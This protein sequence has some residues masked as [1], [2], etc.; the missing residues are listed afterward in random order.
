MKTTPICNYCNVREGKYYFKT[1]NTWCC[2]KH[3]NACPSYKEKNRKRNL[4]NSPHKQLR[5]DLK[6]GK[7]KCY[8]CGF[9]AR[10][11]VTGNR[12]CCK[13][14]ARRC[15]GHYDYISGFK[16]EYY[17]D[18]RS[19]FYGKKRPNHSK[20]LMKVNEFGKLGQSGWWHKKVHELYHTGVCEICGKTDQEQIDDFGRGLTMHCHTEDYTN[21]DKDNWTEVCVVCHRKI[22]SKDGAAYLLKMAS[23]GGR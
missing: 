4:V 22:H 12:P 7:L 10:Y 17:K 21:M 23:N 9:T 3:F 6:D 5:K 16:K 14:S 1:S 19:H 2:E 18:N 20:K 8:I 15:S 13:S 11:L